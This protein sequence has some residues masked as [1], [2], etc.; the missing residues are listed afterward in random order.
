MLNRFAAATCVVGPFLALATLVA[1][2]VPVL[3]P[4]GL[5]RLTSFWCFIPAAWGLWAMLAPRTWV[6]Q[7]LPLW[8]AILGLLVGTVAMVL[9]DLPAH[10]FGLTPSALQRGL[11]ILILVAVYYL[12]WMVVRAAFRALTGN[13]RA[14][15]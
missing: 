10:M 9:L 7:R 13:R 4:E 1:L 8:G 3:K 14:T 5:Y 11:M 6:P 12:L 2:L 15:E